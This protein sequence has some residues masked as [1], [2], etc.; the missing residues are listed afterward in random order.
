MQ[1]YHGRLERSQYNEYS[2]YIS[3]AENFLGIDSGETSELGV[4][5]NNFA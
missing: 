2:D 4:A 5:K 1:F 3:I